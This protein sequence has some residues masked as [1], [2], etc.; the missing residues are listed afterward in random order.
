MKTYLIILILIT[1][2]AWGE[3]QDPVRFIG[4]IARKDHSTFML[5]SASGPQVTAHLSASHL[6]G[7]ISGLLPGDEVM[8]DGHME[9]V[10]S[11]SD[12]RIT[13][14]PIFVIEKLTPISLKRLALA[15]ERLPEPQLNQYTI[16][17]RDYA[18]GSI[19]TS[20]QVTSSLILTASV[21]LFQSLVAPRTGTDLRQDIN[22]GLTLF[23]GTLATGVFLFDDLN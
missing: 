6:E 23:A 22:S 17:P 10:T 20:A 11:Y 2:S 4:R 12:S 5:R 15:Q 18:P 3:T 19:T 13:Y 21:L 14:T 7:V 16:K 9:Y 1:T 8:A